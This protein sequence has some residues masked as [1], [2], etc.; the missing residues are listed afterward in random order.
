MVDD[1]VADTG[2]SGTVE[3][4][5]SITGEIESDNDRDWFAVELRSGRKYEFA[6]HG[7]WT[8]YGTL[9][10]PYLYGVH[11]PNGDLI[12]GTSSNDADFG[13]NSRVSFTV[14]VGGKYY[15]AVGANGAGTGTYTLWV[16]DY[17]GW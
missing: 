8:G 3:V 11:D 10:D 4:G 6:L 12:D 2:T 7:S 1:Y 5:G 16:A 9:D 13:P 14:D 15:I 17:T